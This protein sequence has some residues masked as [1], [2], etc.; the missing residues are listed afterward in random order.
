MRSKRKQRRLQNKGLRDF[1][2][3]AIL[4]IA[5]CA[6]VLAGLVNHFINEEYLAEK[7][8]QEIR[9]EAEIEKV[10]LSW[11]GTPT[12][13]T[14]QGLRLSAKSG[15]V[16]AKG[17][18][19]EVE[20]VNLSVSL[21]LLLWK[22]IDVSNM[23]VRGARVVGVVY[24]DGGSSLEALFESVDREGNDVRRSQERD[25][26]EK[27]PSLSKEK[28]GGFN[29]FDH[30]EFVAS[31][32][33]F[34]LEDAS[35]DLTIEES[36]LRLRCTDLH[37]SLAALE[38]DPR[39][40]E[41]TD[42]A[43]M[44]MG[45][46][47]ALDSIKG[48][49]YGDIDI[50]GKAKARLFNPETGDM[51]PDLKGVFELG[52]SSWLNTRIPVIAEAWQKLE[53][54]NELGIKIE[55][56]PEKATFGRSE[57]V[58][59]HY[60]RG[61]I[62]VLQPLSIWVGDWEVAILDDSWLHTETNQHKIQAELLA[63]KAASAGFYHLLAKMMVYLPKDVGEIVSKDM[64]ENLFRE[65]RLLVRVKS[66]KD[67]SDPKIRLVDGIPD[68]AKAVEKAGK[69]LLQEKAGGLLDGLFGK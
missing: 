60:H 49:H 30:E 64:K 28:E 65:D 58:A 6:G 52:D 24:E 10:E 45:V 55:P 39:R 68:F 23:T 8:E 19:V 59:A 67:L 46:Q 33:G 9:C 53:A 5:L 7:I 44:T 66:S 18:V 38:V 48:W 29:A 25:R 26:H 50:K 2:L 1:V 41:A 47:V 32:G 57:A 13:L 12:Q 61:E 16:R 21:W 34:F 22:R 31:L 27:K 42:E 17:A 63:S 69:K 15:D 14:L 51:E 62:T 40:L 37:I 20:E 36:G 43:E 3:F 54:L 11:F 35:V 4:G 56:L